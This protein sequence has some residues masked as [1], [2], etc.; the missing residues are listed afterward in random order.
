MGCIGLSSNLGFLFVLIRVPSMHTTANIFLAS[1][2]M[3]DIISLTSNTNLLMWMHLDSPILR[4]IPTGSR[5][6]CVAFFLPAYIS[7]CVTATMATLLAFERYHS[8]TSPIKYRI[9]HTKKR[10]IQLIAIMWFVGV[11]YACIVITR[12][13][14]PKYWCIEWPAT[15]AFLHLPNIYRKCV[16]LNDA[17]FIISESL[18]NLIFYPL[19]LTNIILYAKIIQALKQRKASYPGHPEARRVHN[20]V[21]RVLVINGLVFFLCQLPVRLRTLNNMLKYIG[22]HDRS[23]LL[24]QQSYANGFVIGSATLMF[25]NS[26]VNP[27]IYSGSAYYRNAIWEAF[28]LKKAKSPVQAYVIDAMKTGSTSL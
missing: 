11:L 28:G 21:T 2:A 15:K 12:Y 24:I 3:A 8:I 9:L 17:F 23:D 6:V 19:L 20:Q 26:A 4:N 16:A 13:A 22:G 1:W 14:Q 7:G 5:L 25:F 27:F 18:Q 10:A